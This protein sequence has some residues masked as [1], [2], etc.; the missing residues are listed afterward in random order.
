MLVAKS[1]LS[2]LRQLLVCVMLLAVHAVAS[3]G[4]GANRT[5]ADDPS[6]YLQLHAG[7]PVHWRRWEGSSMEQARRSGRLAFITV[8][9]FSCYW[10]HVMR[11]ESFSDGSIADL[12]NTAFV[13]VKV[14]RELEPALV[15]YLNAFVQATRCWAPCICHPS[16]SGP[17]CKN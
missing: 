11:R 7:D 15:E 8:G 1:Q 5:L 14:D 2:R 16:S 9:Y 10:C 12:L 17:C 4:H 13:P 6:P 3:A